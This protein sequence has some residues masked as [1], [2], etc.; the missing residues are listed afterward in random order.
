MQKPP[1]K[2]NIKLILSLLIGYILYLLVEVSF[3]VGLELITNSRLTHLMKF[4]M[5]NFPLMRKDICNSIERVFFLGSE[6]DI[7]PQFLKKDFPTLLGKDEPIDINLPKRNRPWSQYKLRKI[8]STPGDY[9]MVEIFEGGV[10]PSAKLGDSY[11]HTVVY[12]KNA[13]GEY[14]KIEHCRRFVI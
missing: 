1:R 3:V 8:V 2:I 13:D 12:K 4:K 9:I 5:R 11:Y 14:S 6:V 10:L 7:D